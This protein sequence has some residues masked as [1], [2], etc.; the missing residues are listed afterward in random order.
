MAIDMISWKLGFEQ[1]DDQ[2]PENYQAGPET[3]CVARKPRIIFQT[4]EF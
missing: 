1:H 2:V 4:P 3:L